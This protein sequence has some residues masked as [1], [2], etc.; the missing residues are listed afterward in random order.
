MIIVVM[1]LKRSGTSLVAQILQ[2]H[3]VYMG[4][5]FAPPL[6]DWNPDGFFEDLDF[7]EALADLSDTCPSFHNGY[8]KTEAPAPLQQLKDLVAQR[9]SSQ[10]VWGLKVFALAPLLFTFA[11]LCQPRQ[12]RVVRPTR[13]FSSCVCSLSRRTGVDHGVIL[14]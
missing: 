2:Q 8:L 9:N 14:Q 11:D 4:T 6:P 12:V 1:G 7:T 5:R 10:P 13:A 3:G